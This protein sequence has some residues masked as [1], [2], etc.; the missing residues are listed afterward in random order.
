MISQI[1]LNVHDYIT[2]L[3]EQIVREPKKFYIAYKASQNIVCM[4]VR[5]QHVTLFLKLDP[6]KIAMPA[7][8]RDV[9]DIGHSTV[10]GRP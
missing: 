8:G 4:E 9:S 1:A 6:K 10:P 3:D 7:N 2:G 5:K